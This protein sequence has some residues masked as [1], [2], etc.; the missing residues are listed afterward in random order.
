MKPGHRIKDVRHQSINRRGKSKNIPNN[1][2]A[3]SMRICLSVFLTSRRWRVGK[4]PKP[5][6]LGGIVLTAIAHMTIRE[7]GFLLYRNAEAKE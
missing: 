7:Q 3:G 2:D 6:H 4:S 5:T 1:R